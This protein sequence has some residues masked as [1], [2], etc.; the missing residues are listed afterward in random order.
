[1][2]LRCIGHIT[3]MG[4]EYITQAHVISI[5]SFLNRIFDQEGWKEVEDMNELNG[6]DPEEPE[7][8]SRVILIMSLLRGLVGHNNILRFRLTS[9]LRLKYSGDQI[10]TKYNNDIDTCAASHRFCIQGLLSIG[11]SVLLRFPANPV[12][13][14]V[15]SL[16]AGAITLSCIVPMSWDRYKKWY[17]SYDPFF[18]STG[19][20]DG[21]YIGRI[22]NSSSIV[23]GHSI[24]DI[25]R[26]AECIRN[27][28]N[29]Y[30][31]RF[32]ALKTDIGISVSNEH[33]VDHDLMFRQ[34]YLQPASPE[35]L[36][37]VNGLFLRQLVETNE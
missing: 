17:P 33:D 16:L 35:M 13:A 29:R 4:I 22:Y 25:E 7:N 1:M 26:Y 21:A 14:S 30:H 32:D 34:L 3:Q 18:F 10:L 8:P 5:C 36:S 11:D 23:N 2:F 12:T 27:A 31:A 15:G 20:L 6:W 24:M 37:I 19:L 9:L 28:S